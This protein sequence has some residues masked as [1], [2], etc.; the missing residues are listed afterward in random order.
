M[1][2][3]KDSE[4]RKIRALHGPRKLEGNDS[5]PDPQA[6]GAANDQNEGYVLIV[7][8]TPYL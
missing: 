5:K 2:G 1:G 4:G 6:Y 8:I 7:D 3:L